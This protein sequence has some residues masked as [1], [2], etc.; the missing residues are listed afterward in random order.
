MQTTEWQDQKAR[1]TN[2]LK[3]F[4]KPHLTYRMAVVYKN[5]KRVHLYG[6]EQG[7]SS[8]NQLIYGHVDFIKLSRIKGYT[9]LLKYYEKESRGIVS[10]AIYMRQKNE[11]LFTIKCRAWYNGE[12]QEINDP[13][14]DGSNDERILFYQVDKSRNI[15]F[16][17]LPFVANESTKPVTYDRHLTHSESK[18]DHIDFKKE[19]S[20]ALN[21]TTLK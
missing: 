16:S 14:I 1:Q 5:G 11:N 6:N 17:E 20:Q 13:L 3:H 15:I 10:A 21:K 9:D 19:V 4:L 8:Y 18:V 7:I 2:N 12:V